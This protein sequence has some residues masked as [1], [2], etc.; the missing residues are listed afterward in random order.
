MKTGA[1]FLFDLNGT[2]VDDMAFHLDAWYE[3]IVD[4]LGAKMTRDE[5]KHQLY[6]K[7][8]ELLVRIF[9]TDR[10]TTE[11]IA[12]ICLQKEAKYSM[13]YRPHVD[14]IPGLFSFLERAHDLGIPM[15]LGTASIKENISLVIDTLKI[16]HY[17]SAIVGADDV[18]RSKPHPETF[19]SA[20][21][22]LGVAASSCIVFEDAPKG[23]EAAMNA[24]MRA[25][26]ITTMHEPKEFECYTNIVAFV[27]DYTTLEPHRFTQFAFSA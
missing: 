1:A 6:G 12:A 17:F 4:D 9:G 23:V 20:A 11:E 7:S 13:R 26:V 22:K 24:G 21:Q 19:L 27:Q 14:L 16:S 8:E 15:A 5:V 3:I 18:A 2:M 25:V 10:F